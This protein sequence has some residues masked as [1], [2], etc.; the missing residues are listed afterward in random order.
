MSTR[1]LFDRAYRGALER[2]HVVH[3]AAVGMR[4]IAA[5][6]SS[7]RSGFCLGL[8][9]PKNVYN[10]F[11]FAEQLVD[12]AE[13]FQAGVKPH[14]RKTFTMQ[15]PAHNVKHTFAFHEPL[16]PTCGHPLCELY[17]MAGVIDVKRRLPVPFYEVPTAGG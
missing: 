11:R 17:L 10:L 14:C 4:Q 16:C 8:D 3:A 6:D 2:G 12:A 15:C 9:Q 1:T 13:E 5:V 7:Q